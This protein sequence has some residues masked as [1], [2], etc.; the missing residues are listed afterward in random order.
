LIS[1][2]DKCLFTLK[3]DGDAVLPAVRAVA[4]F[5]NYVYIGLAPGVYIYK[6]DD[7]GTLTKTGEI[8]NTEKAKRGA[9]T[10]G[11]VIQGNRLY[12]ALS[13]G[14]IKWYDLDPDT[15]LA[16]EKGNLKISP[17][18][19]TSEPELLFSPD[20]EHMYMWA[21]GRKRTPSRILWLKLDEKGTPSLGE[22]LNGQEKPGLI[23]S[24]KPYHNLAIS[25]DGK[26]L[27]NIS[28]NMVLR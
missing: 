17:P 11:L 27:Y 9:V 26:N 25:S 1:A 23:G 12:D 8:K 14:K 5:K 19:S 2:E 22:E 18:G 16:T 15:G 28:G 13:V 20:K 6:R 10:H 3:K 21:N 4:A 24:V 7:A